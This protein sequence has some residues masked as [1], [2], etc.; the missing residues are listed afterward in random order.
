MRGVPQPPEYHPE[1]DVWIH[2]RMMLE[3]L[4]ADAPATLA[5]AVL[6]H[7]VGKPPTFRSAEQTGDRIRF[8]EH[9]EIGARM[10]AEICRRLRFSTDD[11]SQIEALVANHLRFK[12]VFDM[13]PSTLKR[14]IRLPYFDQH[15]E[16]HRLDCSCSH[17]KLDAYEFVRNFIRETPPDQVRPPR[18]VTGD[19]LSALGLSPG[20]L[21]KEIL[22]NVEEG[23]LEGRL[24]DRDQALDF[25][26]SNYLKIKPLK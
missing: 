22:E 23:Q 2:T 3:M 25:V 18:L 19:D 16:L 11:S 5:W 7:D 20:P 12:D 4:R 17:G 13:R 10:A 24:S 8:N 26:R 9:A 6:L 14:F 15:L 21:F 1:G